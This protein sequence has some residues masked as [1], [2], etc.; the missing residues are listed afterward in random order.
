MIVLPAPEAAITRCTARVGVIAVGGRAIAVDVGRT[1][2]TRHRRKQIDQSAAFFFRSVPT[3][4]GREV[5]WARGG[6]RKGLDRDE[7]LGTFT[8][9]IGTGPVGARRRHAPRYSKKHTLGQYGE[10]AKVGQVCEDGIG[11]QPSEMEVKQC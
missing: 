5:R 6:H 10:F 7:D 3:C 9:E 2:P 4:E 11:R 1:Q 8:G